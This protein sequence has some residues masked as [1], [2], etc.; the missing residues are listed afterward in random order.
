[1]SNKDD[2]VLKSNNNKYTE[3]LKSFEL[4]FGTELLFKVKSEL[5]MSALDVVTEQ[6]FS[7]KVCL[8]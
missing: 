5:K 4:Q 2:N 8:L 7:N 1:M 3:Y 6:F